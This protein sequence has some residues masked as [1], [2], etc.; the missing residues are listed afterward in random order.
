MPRLRFPVVRSV[1]RVRSSRA[2]MASIEYVVVV[3]LI[4]IVSING[5]MVLNHVNRTHLDEVANTLAEINAGEVATISLEQQ[6][7]LAETSQLTESYI[8]MEW[9]TIASVLFTV[10]I[11]FLYLR[12]R[13]RQHPAD[14]E[15][16]CEIEQ[17]QSQSKV[18]ANIFRKRAAIK[19]FLREEWI[20]LFE[21]HMRVGG[22]MSTELATV[23]PETEI[24]EISETLQRDGYR[25]VLVVDENQHLLGIVSQTDIA[26][27]SGKMAKDI[28]TVDPKTLTP[29]CELSIAITVLLRHRISCLPVV[30]GEKLVGLITTSDLLMIL[31]CTLVILSMPDGATTREERLQTIENRLHQLNAAIAETT[32]AI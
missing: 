3:A 25:R 8:E 31:Q 15:S 12:N 1:A 26:K 11:G 13:H 22:Y 17:F 2:G 28:M 27:K 24:S 32:V 23:G 19:S 30:D 4:L 18:L 6:R 7:Q 16:T 14:E 29:D 9:L 21:G 5:V 10:I 20:Q